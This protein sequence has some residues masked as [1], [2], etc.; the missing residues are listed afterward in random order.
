MSWGEKE[1]LRV[2]AFATVDDPAVKD[3]SKVEPTDYVK[4]EVCITQIFDL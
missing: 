1:A 2:L 3:L 4:Y